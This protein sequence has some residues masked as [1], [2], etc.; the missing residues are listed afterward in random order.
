M[1]NSSGAEQLFLR[2]QPTLSQPPAPP[3]QPPPVQ[4]L[5]PETVTPMGPSLGEGMGSA[6]TSDYDVLTKAVF[7]K[8]PPSNLRKS[9]FFHFVITLYDGN[10][11]PVEVERGEFIGFPDQGNYACFD[12]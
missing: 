9:N 6:R 12:F 4:Q 11:N 2:P 5:Q 3:T 1:N 10:E 8:A 7:E